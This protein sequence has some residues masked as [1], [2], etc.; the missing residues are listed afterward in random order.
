MTKM[1]RLSEG[2]FEPNRKHRRHCIRIILIILIFLQ[3]HRVN[4]L[5]IYGIFTRKYVVVI[6]TIR[7]SQAR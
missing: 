4:I 1:S 5:V 2:L 7:K 6:E 3:L